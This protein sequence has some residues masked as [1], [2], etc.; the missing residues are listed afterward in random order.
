MSMCIDDHGWPIFVQGECPGSIPRKKSKF[1][2]GETMLW[3]GASVSTATFLCLEV[4]V[5]FQSGQ[6]TTM[7]GVVVVV[8]V[9]VVL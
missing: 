3:I 1:I 6:S 9:V 2:Q 7:K 5:L 8:V 4:L